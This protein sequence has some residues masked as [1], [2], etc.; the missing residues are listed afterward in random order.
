MYKYSEPK[1]DE[2][3]GV[4]YRETGN[5]YVA[6]NLTFKE[7]VVDDVISNVTIAVGDAPSAV[8]TDQ[9][10]IEK[11]SAEKEVSAL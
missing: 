3:R 9:W 10:E 6:T 2:A 11:Q 5:E 8:D 1:K 4:M 7:P